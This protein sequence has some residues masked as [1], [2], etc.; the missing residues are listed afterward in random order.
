MT[1]TKREKND[2]YNDLPPTDTGSGQQATYNAPEQQ[3]I[4]VSTLFNTTVSQH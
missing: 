2:K 1:K 3:V 4:F